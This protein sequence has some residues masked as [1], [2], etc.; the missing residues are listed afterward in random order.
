MAV[1][2]VLVVSMTFEP[3]T[4]TILGPILE[5]TVTKLS[6]QLPLLCTLSCGG[7]RKLPVFEKVDTPIRHWRLVLNGMIAEIPSKMGLM[8]ALLDALEEEG[9]WGF[10][11]THAV[12]TDFE[13]AYQFF[14]TKK[15]R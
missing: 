10:H 2:P 13:E 7:R 9:D 12:T 14:F 11:D 3:P 5:T 6:H 15:S 1:P 4:I 8:L